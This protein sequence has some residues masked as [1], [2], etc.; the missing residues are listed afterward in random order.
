MPPWFDLLRVPMAAAETSRLR[1]MRL[2]LLALC[3]ALG[4]A[5]LLFGPLHALT[6]AA[7]PCLVAAL[8]FATALHAAAYFAVKTIADAA[9]PSVEQRD[10]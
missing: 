10:P 9:R 7:A 1:R 5:T 4:F 3:C 6:G 2:A 8:I